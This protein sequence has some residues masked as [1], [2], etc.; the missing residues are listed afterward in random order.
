M[1]FPHISLSPTVTFGGSI[2]FLLFGIIYL[3]ESFSEYNAPTSIPSTTLS[4]PI[5]NDSG[6]LSPVEKILA[7]VGAAAAGIDAGVQDPLAQT[8]GGA[9][10]KD[11]V[12]VGADVRRLTT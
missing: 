10:L 7:D 8:I 6:S 11:E 4:N 12:R 5:L 9:V 1:T 3:F 2:L